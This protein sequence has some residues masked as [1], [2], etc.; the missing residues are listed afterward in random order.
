MKIAQGKRS[1][2]LGKQTEEERVLEGRAER[3]LAPYF[4]RKARNQLRAS[5]T[6]ASAPPQVPSRRDRMKIAQGKR[7]EALGKQTEEEPR[8]GGT[9]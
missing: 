8:P 7:S 9:R 4:W 3:T 2:A 6:R 1:E 5:L